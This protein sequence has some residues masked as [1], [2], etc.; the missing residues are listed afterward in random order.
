MV[1]GEMGFLRNDEAMA[2]STAKSAEGSLSFM[3][4]TML[5]KTS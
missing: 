2:E 1:S 3:P 4:P 5:T